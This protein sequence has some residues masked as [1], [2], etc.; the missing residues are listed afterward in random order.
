MDNLTRLSFDTCE[1]ART[2]QL[3]NEK[4][5][6]NL[7]LWRESLGNRPD[8]FSLSGVCD[9]CECL[10]LFNA[11]PQKMPEGDQ[12]LFRVNWWS[13]V[14]CGCGKSS[15]DRN[16]MRN[17][18]DLIKISSRIY[19]V[20]YH[21]SFRKWLSEKMPNVIGAQY[22]PD[23]TPGEVVDGIRYEDLTNLSFLDG[24]L[25]CI[26]CMEVMEHIPDYL[27]GFREMARTLKPGGCAVL[28]F[29]WLGRDTYDH[30]IRAE[31]ESDGSITHI[32]PPEYHGDPASKLGILSFRAFGW[33]VLDE[34][35]EA[36]FSKASANF[37]FGPFHGHFSAQNPVIVAVR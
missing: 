30:L 14:T 31:M 18:L 1:E 37:L 16:V 19:H 17:I 13:A 9:V 2:Y 36:G 15:L 12:F 4:Q 8:P 32:L 22:E 20:G 27:A 5:F 26:V 24:E 25:D 7:W 23:R 33:R 28:T 34:L 29:P 6:V 10:T 3:A 35:R 11:T 21:S